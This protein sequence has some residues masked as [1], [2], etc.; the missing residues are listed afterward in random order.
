MYLLGCSPYRSDKNLGLAYNEAMQLLPPDGWAAFLDHDAIHTTPDWHRLIVGAIEANPDF[1]LFVGCTNRIGCGWM[2]TPG[3]S[4]RNHDMLYH[5]AIGAELA[6]RHGSAVR[7]VTEWERQPGG[8]PLSGVLMVI[9]KRVW[10]HV[11][12]FKNGFL[13]VDNDCHRRVRDADFR[14]GLLLGVYVYHFYRAAVP[15]SCQLP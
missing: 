12:G 15:E 6:K 4:P 11:L 8:H 7:D 9:S 2:K 3:V 5:R 13:T 10:A 14:V 1:G